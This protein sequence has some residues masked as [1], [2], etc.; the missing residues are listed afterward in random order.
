MDYEE[1][2]TR[3]K[4]KLPETTKSTKRFEI[5]KVKGHLQGNKTVI[6]NFS[7]IADALRRDQKHLLKYILKEIAA[8]GEIENNR[9]L[10]GRKV[11]ASVV[12]QKIKKYAEE[13]VLCNECNKPDTKMITEDGI[14]F[15]KCTACGARY[16]SGT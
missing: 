15:V 12:N 16:P 7:K 14:E 3:G 2:L 11:S 9:V 5:P 8:P 6:S 10:I 1:L 4:E 13:Y